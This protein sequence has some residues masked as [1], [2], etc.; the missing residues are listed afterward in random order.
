M[1]NMQLGS[2][3]QVAQGDILVASVVLEKPWG[4]S[5]DAGCWQR[6]ISGSLQGTGLKLRVRLRAGVTANQMCLLRYLEV[7][8]AGGQVQGIQD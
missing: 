8:P 7:F 1:K 3:G 5:G 2:T 4:R 6:E